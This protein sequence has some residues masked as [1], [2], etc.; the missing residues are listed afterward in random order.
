MILV[1]LFVL[2]RLRAPISDNKYM[3]ISSFLLFSVIAFRDISVGS[4]TATYKQLFMISGDYINAYKTIL[5]SL[6]SEFLFFLTAH[7]IKIFGAD[8]RIY[9][10]LASF[11]IIYAMSVFFKRY[12]NSLF[13]SYWLYITLGL[14]GLSMSGLR[15]ILA[16]SI[17]LLTFK[18]LVNGNKV[19]YII[20]IIIAGFFHFSAFIMLPIFL[21]RKIKLTSKMRYILLFSTI[22]FIF[23]FNNVII[24]LIQ[25]LSTG[26]YAEY[27]SR[28]GVAGSNFLL[29]LVSIGITFICAFLYRNPETDDNGGGSSLIKDKM[30]D[31]FYLMSCIN[32]AI[33]IVS[34]NSDIV[35]RIGY[36][37]FAFNLVLLPNAI[38]SIKDKKIRMIFMISALLV[39]LAQF[40]ISTP[41]SYLQIDKY[42]FFW[43]L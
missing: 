24:S 25:G 20:G 12:S 37:F 22:F 6:S 41:G 19:K 14:F 40:A 8:F 35:S 16:L 33:M 27:N 34:V 13:I 1:Y 26:R 4:D 31:F 32:V 43:S 11:F 7:I 5:P 38:M 42:I 23:V 9:L 21:F 3:I 29:I 18:Y 36:Y 15:Q 28:I 30:F 17:V 10:A 39:S 2:Q